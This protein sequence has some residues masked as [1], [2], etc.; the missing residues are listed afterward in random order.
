M[1]MPRAQFLLVLLATACGQGSSGGGALDALRA[2]ALPELPVV[3]ELVDY[4]PDLDITIAEMRMLTSGLLLQDDSVGVGDSLVAGQTAV[5]HYT[6][7]LPDGTRFDTSRESGTPFSFRVG[8]GEVI[9][10]WDEGVIGMRV[11]G[12][13]KL[14]IPPTIGYGA[15]GS[16]SVPPNA[17]M[18]FE[19]ELL[20]IRR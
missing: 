16:G 1:P 2:P 14:V 4:H 9:E 15:E 3:P 17:I 11:G 5:V 6:G 18:V 20:E 12:R 19:I 10:A 7:W 13:R 8:A